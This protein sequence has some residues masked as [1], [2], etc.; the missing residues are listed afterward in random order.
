MGGFLCERTTGD[1]SFHWSNCY[2][3]LWIRVLAGSDCLKL[4]WWI[5]FLQ[6]HIFWLHKTLTDGLEWCG[7]LWCFYQL[8]GLSFWRHLFTAEH[9]LLSKWC[10]VTFL[11]IWWRNNFIYILY[12]LRVSTFNALA[13]CSP[14]YLH[15]CVSRRIY[16][17]A[18]CQQDELIQLQLWATSI[19][20]LVFIE[21]I[22]C[23]INLEMWQ[24]TL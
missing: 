14:L 18:V 20:L 5:C 21:I 10:N 2:Y 15:I 9:P 1:G 8:F 22:V 16:I 4:T 24:C 7:L 23:A 11:Q 13:K 12:V 19:C 17:F 6:T 3:E